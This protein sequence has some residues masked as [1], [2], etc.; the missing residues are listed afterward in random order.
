MAA[1]EID[2]FIRKFKYLW[3]AGLD[4]R[5]NIETTA[6]QAWVSLH[7]RLGHPPAPHHV[8]PSR[9]TKDNHTIKSEKVVVVLFFFLIL[10]FIMLITAYFYRPWTG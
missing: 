2:T 9:K 8:M 10:I 4:A 7:L 3:S 5:L 1:E 6:G